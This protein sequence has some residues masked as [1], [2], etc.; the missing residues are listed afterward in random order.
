[1]LACAR[2][3]VCG[4]DILDTWGCANKKRA[5]GT[6]HT[7]LPCTSQVHPHRHLAQLCIVNVARVRM[8]SSFSSVD[9]DV[10]PQTF[11]SI[12]FVAVQFT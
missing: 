11:L 8:S 12:V 5:I 1:M 4:L 7:T 9:P 2:R 10:E 3:I 6:P